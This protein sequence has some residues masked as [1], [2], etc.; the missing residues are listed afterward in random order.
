MKGGWGEREKEEEHRVAKAM[1]KAA[2]LQD[3]AVLCLPFVNLKAAVPTEAT[4]T[5]PSP[6]A[7]VPQWVHP[8]WP[9][10]HFCFV[11]FTADGRF[12]TF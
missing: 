6:N 5:A 7:P 11:L 4:A 3:A 8:P 1:E 12:F 2:P 10:G 9:Q